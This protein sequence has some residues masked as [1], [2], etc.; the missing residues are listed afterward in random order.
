MSLIPELLHFFTQWRRADALPY[1]VI[2]GCGTFGSYLANELSRRGH[3]VVVLDADAHAFEQ[4]M[5]DFA[6]F[7]LVGDAADLGVLERAHLADAD[8]VIAATSE[9]LLNYMVVLI[10]MHRYGKTAV[11]ARVSHPLRAAIIRS[12]GIQTVDPV[13][14][15]AEA[16]FPS[17]LPPSTQE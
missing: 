14:Y 5:P 15:A 2:V 9:D 10:A 12:E 13:A 7:T 16:L 8:L 4:L 11:L 17:L 6:G 1:V 3:S